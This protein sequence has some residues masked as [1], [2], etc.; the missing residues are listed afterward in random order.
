MESHLKKSR[1]QYGEY[2]TGDDGN[3]IGYENQLANL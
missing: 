2:W 3:Q 1:Y